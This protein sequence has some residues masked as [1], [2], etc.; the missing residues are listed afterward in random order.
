MMLLTQ[1]ASRLILLVTLALSAVPRATAL[2][3][4]EV[5]PPETPKSAE[6]DSGAK[7]LTTAEVEARLEALASD[8]ALEDSAKDG[9]RTKYQQALEA[10]KEAESFTANAKEF[11][12]AINAAPAEAEKSRAALEEMPTAEAAETADPSQATEEV[13]KQVDSKRAALNDLNEQLAGAKRSLSRIKQRP[14]EISERLPQAQRELS[15]TEE[16]LKSSD[17]AEQ[18]SSPGR[19][20]DRAVLLAQQARL[21]SEIEMLKQEQASLAAREDRQEAQTELLARQVENADAT[22]KSLEALLLERLAGEATRA[23]ALA[24]NAPQSVPEDD[25]EAQELAKEV[26]AL[27]KEFETVVEAQKSVATVRDAVT[28][29]Q[30]SLRAEYEDLQ[31]QLESG[32]AGAEMVQVLFD[33]ER[34]IIEA[35]EDVLEAELPALGKTRLDALDIESKLRE[36]PEVE[37]RFE[38]HDSKA[39]SQLVAARAELLEKLSVQYAS[40]TRS[41]AAFDGETRQ[42]LARLEAVRDEI[43][44]QLFWMRSSPPVSIKTITDLPGGLRWSFS[45]EHARELW[46]AARRAAVRMPVR[47]TAVLL[48]VVVLLLLRPWI[49]RRLTR[50][51]ERTRRISTDLYSHTIE[52]LVWT[53]LLAIP[54]PLTIGLIGWA[55]AQFG[56]ASAWLQDL[57]LGLRTC[58]AVALAATFFASVLRPG[59]LGD[60]HFGWNATVVARLRRAIRLT[61]LIYIPALVFSSSH[62]VFRDAPDFLD[63][64]GRVAFFVAHAWTALVLWQLLSG[65]RG[66]LAILGETHPGGLAGRTRYLWNTLA[67]VCPLSLIVL[68]AMGYLIT[69]MELSLGL[70]LT[71]SIVG[72]GAVLYGLTLRWFVIRER[73]LALDEA[74]ERRRARQEATQSADDH[75]QAG[76]VV[77]VDRDEE[78]ELDLDSIGVQTRALLRLLFGLGVAGA[79]LLIWPEIVPLVDMLEAVQIPLA[80]GPTLLAVGQALVVAV[81]TLI[82]VHNLPGLLE[83]AVLRA[84]SIEAGTRYAVIMLCKYA[85]VAVGFLAVCSVLRV[86]WAQ[87]GWIAAALSVGLG[88]GLQEVVAN[89]VCGVV[90]LFERP[91][92]VGDVVTVDNTTG[93][94]TR[95][96]MRA[97]TI[98]NWDRQEYVVP[99]KELITGKILNWTLSASINRLKIPVGVAYGTDTETARQILLDVAADHPMVIDDPPPLATFDE[100]A[101]SSLNLTLYAYLENIDRRLSTITELHTEIDKRFAAAG[102]TIPFPQRDL[103]I[104][105]AA[106]EQPAA[107]SEWA[108]GGTS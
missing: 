2:T 11:R 50:A 83:L 59:G 79:I 51:G 27:A 81:V 105:N 14:L 16:K 10:L 33:L 65:P 68:A 103:H 66:I 58:A 26:Q 84:I 49:V 77:S 56:N 87:F 55:L 101:D 22:L 62:F 69:A 57:A 72:A 100:F 19:E 89:F 90:L 37:A 15:D 31:G 96:R 107:D 67:L 102:I 82:V 48:T 92:R 85:V 24:R 12:Q 4:Q 71:A 98:T 106:E 76:E 18:T 1:P 9:L 97:T 39:V 41:V 46:S 91:I 42:Y 20:A 75:E 43:S 44:E 53:V 25:E 93:T 23:E 54:V 34:R 63:S 108:D 13:Q 40:L 36:Q 70:V 60:E 7:T 21:Q 99:N 32:G 28:K 47:A 6:P 3:A 30:D 5:S 73:R 74:I 45:A 104:Q 61:A 80:G 86:D 8:T 88:F 52:A 94:V 78:D 29:Q 17:F 35:Q 95:I 64:V 38:D